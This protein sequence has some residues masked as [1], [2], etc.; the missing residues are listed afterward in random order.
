MSQSYSL[1]LRR[2]IIGLIEEG[3]SCRAAARHFRVSAKF[4]VNLK[5]R[6]DR[7]G[8]VAPDRRGRPSRG[9]KFEP[10]RAFLLQRVA[11]EPD[12]AMP[13]LA[14]ELEREHGVKAA[15]AELSRFLCRAGYSYK[16]R[17]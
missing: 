6:W 2:R 11:A 16:K 1:D 17:R 9:S 14:H 8:T 4:A 10:H 12:I 13:Q 15:P 3:H 7:R 5:R